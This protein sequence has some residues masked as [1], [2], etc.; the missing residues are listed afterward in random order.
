MEW[1]NVGWSSESLSVYTDPLSIRAVLPPTKM[2]L[3]W[4][5]I[6]SVIRWGTLC[7]P[8][9]QI[10]QKTIHSICFIPAKPFTKQP[11]ILCSYLDDYLSFQKI[12]T[13]E[14]LCVLTACI[15]GLLTSPPPVPALKRQG[16]CSEGAELCSN[17]R[18]ANCGVIRGMPLHAW[19]S[20][21]ISKALLSFQ[22][23]RT[24]HTKQTK[25]KC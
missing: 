20:R 16:S 11:P 22:S 15:L 7:C 10:V 19:Q 18:D 14:P 24:P 13:H 9:A 12:F 25:K 5:P 8:A 17:K 3:R 2:D 23:A 6:I 1:W 4:Q 21:L